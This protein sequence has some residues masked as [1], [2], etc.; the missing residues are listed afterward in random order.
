MTT[1]SQSVQISSWPPPE[2]V[3]TV[4]GWPV[5]QK[6]MDDI[7]T[8]LHLQDLLKAAVFR[9]RDLISYL[10]DAWHLGAQGPLY[11][12]ML[13]NLEFRHSSV[14]LTLSPTCSCA[15]IVEDESDRRSILTVTVNTDDTSE[16]EA[17]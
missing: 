6:D 15:S 4:Q 13:G 11:M 16:D 14:A 7:G 8:T 17:L 12:F 1:V 9:H 5:L 10:G 3:T 2:W